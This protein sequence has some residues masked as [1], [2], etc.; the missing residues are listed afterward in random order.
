M[1]QLGTPAKMTALPARVRDSIQKSF[2]KA[3]F[4][5]MDPCVRYPKASKVNIIADFLI[6]QTI[7]EEK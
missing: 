3:R 6:L 7:Y 4:L 2:W 5:T 1:P